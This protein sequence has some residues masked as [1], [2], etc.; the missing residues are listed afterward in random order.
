M[1]ISTARILHRVRNAHRFFVDRG[2]SSGRVDGAD[3]LTRSLSSRDELVD[4]EI[5]V[6]EAGVG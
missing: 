6:G 5:G 4:G 2:G 1:A 3:G